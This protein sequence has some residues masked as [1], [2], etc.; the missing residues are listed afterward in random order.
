MAKKK[1]RVTD[2]AKRLIT[3][4]CEALRATNQESVGD[5]LTT[6][7]AGSGKLLTREGDTF[8]LRP[9]GEMLLRVLLMH[10]TTRGLSDV[11]RKTLCF[12]AMRNLEGE[13]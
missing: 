10:C 12:T 2:E 13:A 8:V 11:Q 5:Y 7:L 6:K 1:A 9:K 4:V 3:S